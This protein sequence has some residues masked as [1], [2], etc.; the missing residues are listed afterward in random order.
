MQKQW[1]IFNYLHF[2]D[3][4]RKDQTKLFALEVCDNSD[5]LDELQIG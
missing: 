2:E 3:M 5:L 1:K 4:A